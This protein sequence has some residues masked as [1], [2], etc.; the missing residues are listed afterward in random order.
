MYGEMIGLEKAINEASERGDEEEL[1][2]LVERYRDFVSNLRDEFDSGKK[3]CKQ[4]EGD[5]DG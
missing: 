5:F 3:K 1:D 2:S 4:R